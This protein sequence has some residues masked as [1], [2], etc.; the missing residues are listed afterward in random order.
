MNWSQ[1]HEMSLTKIYL[2]AVTA[3]DLY[4]KLSIE[5]MRINIELSINTE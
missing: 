1:L 3:S 5:D 2:L 4:S